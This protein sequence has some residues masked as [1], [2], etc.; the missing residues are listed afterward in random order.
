MCCIGIGH[1]FNS[2]NYATCASCLL[3]DTMAV[4][5]QTPIDATMSLYSCLG[6]AVEVHF[7]YYSPVT[8]RTLQAYTMLCMWYRGLHT[9]EE[10]KDS[11]STENPR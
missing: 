11:N 1:N 4:I 7:G 6:R 10:I 5:W 8:N 2:K 9:P 3:Y